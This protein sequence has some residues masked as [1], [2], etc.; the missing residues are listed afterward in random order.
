MTKILALSLTLV[1]ATL[2]FA[3]EGKPTLPAPD[4]AP[5]IDTAAFRAKFDSLRQTRDTGR[6]AMKMDTAA[7]HHEGDVRDTG[8]KAFGEHMMKADSIR[9]GKFDTAKAGEFK[10]KMDSLRKDWSAK[11][12]SQIT[13][14]KDTAVQAKLRDRV[15]KIEAKKIEVKAKIEAKKAEVKATKPVAPVAPAAN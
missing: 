10:A 14:V 13:K 2:S 12:D 3:I 8:R 5:R 15:K 9:A 4:G 7:F 11:R 1:A 6:P